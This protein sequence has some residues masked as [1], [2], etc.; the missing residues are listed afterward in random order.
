VSDTDS[1]TSSADSD[2]DSGNG[3]GSAS[4]ADIIASCVHTEPRLYDDTATVVLPC[5]KLPGFIEEG[6]VYDDIL[7]DAW[8]RTLQRY[9]ASVGDLRLS[10]YRMLGYLVNVAAL[11]G[12]FVPDATGYV[13]PRNDLP[14]ASIFCSNAAR[15]FRIGV[16]ASPDGNVDSLNAAVKWY[17]EDVACM[18][19][20]C[21]LVPARTL[22]FLNMDDPV[23]AVV[24]ELYACW[25][26][27][28]ATTVK[29]F[30]SYCM[31][32][33]LAFFN[34][35]RAT[36]TIV[37]ASTQGTREVAMRSCADPG[38]PS[39]GVP[40]T[41]GQQR[42]LTLLAVRDRADGLVKC[43]DKADVDFILR[44][45]IALRLIMME[46]RGRVRRPVKVCPSASV[47][48]LFCIVSVQVLK[49]LKKRMKI[50][51]GQSPALVHV[52]KIA[53]VYD[54]MDTRPSSKLSKVLHRYGVTP[55]TGQH[56]V[57]WAK[58]NGDA[59]HWPF[60]YLRVVQDTHNRKCGELHFPEVCYES[61]A[62]KFAAI[63]TAC[64][65]LFAVMLTT[66]RH[67]QLSPLSKAT[68]RW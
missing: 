65:C 22:D 56:L 53:G 59:V 29:T 64:D 11:R 49:R 17:D 40:L 16:G 26:V 51:L 1:L 41:R 20:P 57:K 68:L 5:D 38:V 66:C 8:Q 54:V 48:S 14:R 6:T 23:T 45:C 46:D 36:M 43:D 67:P 13:P 28:L 15:V 3:P 2:G 10:T 12:F 27:Q 30:N 52:R 61:C 63:L 62:F 50:E 7:S 37:L 60:K 19:H 21:G 39:A 35:N 33:A 44:H 9:C 18:E 42:L 34:V 4:M 32:N 47:G 24:D 58:T 31:R 55:A 25:T